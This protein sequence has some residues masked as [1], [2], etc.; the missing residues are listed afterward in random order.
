M[1][2]EH[3]LLLCSLSVYFP[4]GG[5]WS[6][7]NLNFDKMQ[8]ITFLVFFFCILIKKALPTGTF[9]VLSLLLGL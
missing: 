1:C 2:E 7:E 9:Y 4:N 3:F 6:A 8:F 5:V